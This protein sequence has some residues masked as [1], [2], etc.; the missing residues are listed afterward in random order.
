MTDLL[1]LTDYQLLTHPEQE[2][3]CQEILAEVA[4]GKFKP[5][6]E[7]SRAHWQDVWTNPGFL[8]PYIKQGQVLRVNGS[9][10]WPHD[11]WLELKWYVRFRE[12]LLKTYFHEVPAIWEFGCGNG[13]NLRAARQL[14][15][16]K[17][18]V[19][20][21]WAMP[22]L[23]KMPYGP[24]YRQ[25][26]FFKP[27]Y[28]V[29]LPAGTGVWT[30]GALEQTG[31]RWEP[32]LEYLL[33]NKPAVCVHVEPI[34]EW[35]DPKNLVDATAIAYHRVRHYWEGFPHW[36]WQM[37]AQGHVNILEQQR[38]YF[39]SRYLEGYSLNVWRPSH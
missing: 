10:V 24:D 35:Y 6:G 7:S 31:T 13:W 25:F 5:A 9:L 22:A 26:D 11:A 27:D 28:N 1:Q 21:D 36:L 39:G 3:L 16:A 29:K 33:A 18:L 8:P 15:P 17:K 23:G 32:F 4:A 2:A 30:V 20:L 37:V 38:S 14:Y 34:V 19:G 12:T